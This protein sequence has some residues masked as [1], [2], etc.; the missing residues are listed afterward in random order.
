MLSRWRLPSSL[1]PRY[2]P[3]PFAP[4]PICCP[5]RERI[6]LPASSGSD[7]DV[8][9]CCQQ[10]PPWSRSVR[11]VIAGAPISIWHQNLVLLP[12]LL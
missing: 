6:T 7:P 8:K 4:T 12:A 2:L 3:L 9:C 1:V 10:Q 11:H 5:R